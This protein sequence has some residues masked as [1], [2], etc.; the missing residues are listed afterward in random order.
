MV[1]TYEYS[2]P[3]KDEGMVA[4]DPVAPKSMHGTKSFAIQRL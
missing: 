1:A 4:K 2:Y 3:S